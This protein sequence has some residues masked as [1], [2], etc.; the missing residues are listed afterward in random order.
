MSIITK[1]EI[2]LLGYGQENQALLL[3]L[4]KHKYSGHITI[5]DFRDKKTQL[6]L[7]P[8]KKIPA[9][10]KISWQTGTEFNQKLYKHP[11]LVKSP[12]W[13]LACPGIK[14]ALLKGSKLSSA[15][16]YFLELCP[17]KNTIGVSGSKGK[18]TTSTIIS[19]ILKISGKK[20]FLGGNIGVAPF[21]F[22]DQIKKEDWV[23]LELSSFQLEPSPLKLRYSIITNLFKEHLA[24]ADPNNPNYHKSIN[25]YWDAKLNIAR[26]KENRALVAHPNLKSRLEKA[27]LK[28]KII[29]YQASKLDTKLKGIY[30]QENIGAAL[31]LSNFLKIPQ[32]VSEKFI[33]NFKNLENRLEFVTERQ[34]I[35]YY[36][37]SFSTTPESSLLDL[38][39]FSENIIL[40]AGGADKGA[41]FS[42]FAKE[43]K[44]KVKHL[45]L[46]NA[47]ASIKIQNDLL[48]ISY[49]SKL[50][51]LVDSME[52]ALNQARLFAEPGDIILLSTASASFGIFK[53]YKER[54]EL[55][56]FYAKK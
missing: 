9:N 28:T 51:K 45:I 10:L 11:L 46:F 53:N 4:I 39:S 1:K 52:E 13:P 3:W 23:V 19:G 26:H 35:K 49:P 54:G 33:K 25:S 20:V 27:N 15:L 56:R 34:G 2:A 6:L 8:I 16:E 48:K 5:C 22:L 40:I 7:R 43:I 37:N 21:S 29:Y 12:G 36:N 14:E 18:G 47:P 32:E 44:K 30:N 24:P 42:K 38:R 31:S 17:S 55:F 41:D 50:I